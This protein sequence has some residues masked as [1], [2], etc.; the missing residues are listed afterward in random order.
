M[1]MTNYTLVKYIESDVMRY[2]C[3]CYS[4]SR[5]AIKKPY[6]QRRHGDILFPMLNL[7]LFMWLL[8]HV[9]T[10]PSNHSLHTY[11]LTKLVGT[12]DV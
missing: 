11:H 5:Y 8:P 7:R 4:G 2:T 3:N 12:S 9:A 10:F 1:Y 6:L